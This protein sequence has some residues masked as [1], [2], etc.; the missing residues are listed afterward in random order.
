MH[1][2]LIGAIEYGETHFCLLCLSPLSTQSTAGVDVW[3]L[4][5]RS[6]SAYSLPTLIFTTRMLTGSHLLCA[7][8]VFGYL[9]KE[10]HTIDLSV[11]DCRN[12]VCGHAAGNCIL[13]AAQ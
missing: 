12:D 10:T 13:I 5:S 6:V 4:Y 3:R 2:R 1:L 11:A 9:I 7:H 8:Q